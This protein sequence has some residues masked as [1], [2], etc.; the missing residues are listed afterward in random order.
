MYLF[1]STADSLPA[2]IRLATRHRECAGRWA[3]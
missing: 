3:D 1:R 2:L